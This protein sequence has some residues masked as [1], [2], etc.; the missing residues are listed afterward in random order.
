MIIE[1]SEISASGEST[2]TSGNGEE[3]Q[4]K[5]EEK[6][7]VSYETYKKTLAEAKSA[8]AKLRELEAIHNKSA[9]EKMKAEGDWKGLL[10][11]REN[12]IKELEAKTSELENNYSSLNETILESKKLSKIISKLG[13][14]LD[15][16]Y[17]GLIDLKDVKINPETG[18]IDEISAARVAENFKREYPET[19]K[20]RKSSMMMGEAGT[21]GDSGSILTYD[22]W[23]KL[24]Y[25]EKMAR[26][27]EVKNK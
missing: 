15:D 24:P 11:A 21:K 3:N 25:K 26:Y 18:E 9:E 20:P 22:A 23:L 1:N 7:S 17:F 5:K 8:K 27:N 6:G 13:A 2:E 12:Q 19:L 16:K 10:E 4:T 14:H